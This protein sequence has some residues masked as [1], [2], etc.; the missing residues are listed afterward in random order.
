LD[1]I[2]VAKYWQHF[3]A[4]QPIWG[5]PCWGIGGRVQKIGALGLVADLFVSVAELVWAH[6][7]RQG[8]TQTV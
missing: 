1:A 7:Q 6:S 8:A 5:G 2:T 3:V 4:A